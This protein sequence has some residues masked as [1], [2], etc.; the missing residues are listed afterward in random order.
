MNPIHQLLYICQRIEKAYLPLGDR[1]EVYPCHGAGSSCGKSIGDR[2]QST[3]GNERVFS[4]A[5]KQR[6]E[7]E[8][9]SKFR[10]KF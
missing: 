6:T 10:A 3:I 2:R 7:A 9:I 8:L 1:L 4:D 5:F